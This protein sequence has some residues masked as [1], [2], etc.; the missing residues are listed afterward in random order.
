MPLL[1]RMADRIPHQ[2]G[3]P[4]H[5]RVAVRRL[6]LVEP[7][8]VDDA[9]DHLAHL[10]R[11]ADV[12][13]DDPVQLG[14]VERRVGR[15]APLPRL[16]RRVAEVAN[17][18]AADRDGV[19]VVGGQVVGDAREPAVDVGAAQLLGG[20][21]LA[22]RGLHERRPAEEDRAGA[23]HDHGLVGHRRDVRASRRAR[24]HDEG[25][26]G[27]PERRHARLVVEDP[28]EVLAVGED[29]RLERQVRPAGVGQVEAREPVLL[30]DLLGA[31]VLLHGEGEVAPALH[32][33]VV[34]HDDARAARDRADAGH[35]ARAR[36]VAVVEAVG[37][38]RCELQKGAAGIDEPLD[39]LA[40][41]QLAALLV[42][43]HGVPAAARPGPLELGLEVADQLPHPLAVSEV[44][45]R[46]GVE[47]TRDAGHGPQ[48]TVTI[49]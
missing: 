17:D 40:G 18:L 9:A 46:G 2:V 19:L 28:A 47:M 12:G 10:E 49:G 20:H 38:E 27:D 21:L 15:L 5:E 8:A 45:I 30:G 44:V 11:M 32:G 7:R 31:E 6:E 36:R 37:R 24:P 14:R 34:R 43:L 26:L 13:R 41:E 4:A 42:A 16:G 33:R 22:R 48:I 23:A 3:E 29:V 25:D 35:D 1:A 39:P